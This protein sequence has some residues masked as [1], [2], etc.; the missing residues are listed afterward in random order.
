M[1]GDPAKYKFVMDNEKNSTEKGENQED[2]EGALCDVAP[3]VLDLMVRHYCPLASC[4]ALSSGFLYSHRDYKFL[5]VS[6]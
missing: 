1:T 4:K 2:E 5:K 3:T 6:L